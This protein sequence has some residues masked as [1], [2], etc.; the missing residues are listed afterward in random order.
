[1]AVDSQDRVFVYSR[2]E[3][4]LV[5]FDRDGGSLASWGEEVLRD[6]HGLFIDA[7][8]NVY[9]VERNTHVVR[10]F[11]PEGRLVMTLGTPDAP[12]E[13]G[14]PFN[15][16]TDLAVAPDG[17]FYV[18]DG[19]GQA[20]VHRFSPD[21]ELLY[22]W[23]RPGNG[24]GEFHL[25]HSVWV[26]VQGRVFVSDRENGRIQVFDADGGF[27]EQWTGFLQ[28]DDLFFDAEGT[29]YVAELGHRVSILSPDGE[30]LARWGEPGDAP[31]Q[32]LACP[33]GI[34]TDSQGDLYV[35]EVQ[36]DGRLQ[37]FVRKG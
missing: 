34:W 10:K 4:P 1:V 23:G 18:T 26:D 35:S 30:V 8:D 32:F 22:S 13:E 28:P 6:A 7:E 31:G 15:K 24:P 12:G 19:Y 5:V 29:I 2:S 14:Q 27:R 11:D 33:H 17:T 16:P 3:H 21:G 25:P 20:R 37:K 36:A 9:C